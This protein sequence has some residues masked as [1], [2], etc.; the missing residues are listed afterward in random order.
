MSE[1]LH[2]AWWTPDAPT[3]RVPGTLTGVDGGWQLNL[4]GSLLVNW[5]GG[6]GLHLVPPTT[7]WGSCLGIPYTLLHCYLADVTGVDPHATEST[8][9]QWVMKWRVARLVR[10]GSVT[11]TTRFSAAAFEITGLPAWWPLSGLRGPHVR[12]GTYTAPDDVVVPLNG[13]T[14]TIGV[15][16]E[17]HSGRRG[18]SLRERVIVM[19]DRPSGFTLDDV[20]KDVAGPLRALVAIGVDEPVSV[21]NLRLVPAGSPHGAA[22]TR[23]LDVDPHDGKEPETLPSSVPAPFPLAPAVEDI[24]SFLPAWLELARRC[25][26]SLD[27]VEPRSRSGSLQLQLLDVVNAAETLHRSLYADPAEH[28][29]AERVRKAL[30]QSETI[31]FTSRERR[32]V[33]D[34]VKFTEVSLEQRLLALAEGLG[35]EVCTWLFSGAVRPWAFVTARIRNVLSHGFTA[36]DGVHE[37]AGAL[38][39]ALRLTEAVITLRL[40]VE[41]GL[42]SGASLVDRLERHRGMRSLSHQ[43]VADWPALAHR[44]NPQLW[45]PP[46]AE[47]PS[48]NTGENEALPVI[49][50]ETATATSPPHVQPP[51]RK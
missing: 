7:I 5:G 10:G 41:A 15:R 36:S 43:T 24:P 3:V 39:G 18:K 38:A 51:S 20:D 1:Q 29:F 26:V 25:S 23:F 32:A 30:E 31:T 14:I 44:I 8:S 28:P 11:D 22:P 40:L 45:A 19:A 9:D 33:R 35:S 21:F 4:I 47:S 46:E 17:R 50:Q 6:E 16:T 27:S 34:A 2:G 12:A 42:P 37:D 13:G 49:P 48:A